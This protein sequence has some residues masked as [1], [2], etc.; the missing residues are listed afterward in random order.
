MSSIADR[1]AWRIDR[2]VSRPVRRRTEW[3]FWIVLTVFTAAIIAGAVVGAAHGVQ[4]P[5]EAFLVGP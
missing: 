2:Q 3:L 5:S 1:E 4:V